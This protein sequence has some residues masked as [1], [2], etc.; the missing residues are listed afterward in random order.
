MA[1]IELEPL[2]HGRVCDLSG[3]WRGWVGYICV[4]VGR[5][6]NMDHFFPAERNLKWEKWLNYQTK[7]MSSG[8]DD[9]VYLDYTKGFNILLLDGC[10][11]WVSTIFRCKPSTLI[12][13]RFMPPGLWHMVYMP[14]ENSHC[15]RPFLDHGDACSHRGCVDIHL[16]SLVRV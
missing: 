8:N 14:C 16:A 3:P 10:Y 6:K 4:R 1:N 11:L 9:F 13:D 15:W 7:M 5:H 2:D 12:T